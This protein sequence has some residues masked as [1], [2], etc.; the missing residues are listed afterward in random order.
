MCFNILF[1]SELFESE[2]SSSTSW[3][4][5]EISIVFWHGDDD[6]PSNIPQ[7]GLSLYIRVRPSPLPSLLQ[8]AMQFSQAV[9]PRSLGGGGVAPQFYNAMADCYYSF[10]SPLMD[11]PRSSL[12]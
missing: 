4:T 8:F 3:I 12:L 9:R 2:S 6:W 11:A 10:P 1:S 7:V 5:P